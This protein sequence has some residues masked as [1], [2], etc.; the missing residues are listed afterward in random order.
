MKTKKSNP[1]IKIERVWVESAVDESA[2]TSWLGE[3]TD[4]ASDWAID[5]PSG[6]FCCK[7]WQRERIIDALHDK[8]DE[9]ADE[10]D[11]PEY[12]ALLEKTRNRIKKIRESG[13]TETGRMNHEY[14]FFLPSSN[15]VPHNPKNW[16]HV[17]GEERSKV[18]KEHGNLKAADM[19]Y[20]KQDYERME[21]LNNG[22]WCFLGIIAKAKIL[23]PAGNYSQLQT[24]TSGGLWGIE[25]D[26]GDEY[27]REEAQNQLSDLKDQLLALGIGKR[28]IEYAIKQWNGEIE[29]K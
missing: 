22:N 26:S 17:Q 4:K 19:H 13:P 24:I 14:S 2:N 29:R 16:E 7:I 28:A 5:R 23:V 9:Y 12:A 3:Y 11:T 18:I 15:H 25:S 10:T 21:S 20:A 6:E 1:K 8:L 27:I